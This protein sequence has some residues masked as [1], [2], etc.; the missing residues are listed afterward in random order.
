[1][2]VRF[3]YILNKTCFAFI[4]LV[5]TLI[6][7][8]MRASAEIKSDKCDLRL[9]LSWMNILFCMCGS[10]VLNLILR[11][12]QKPCNLKPYFLS[13]SNPGCP[14]SRILHPVQWGKHS[15]VETLLRP[16][17]W[18]PTGE[19]LLTT[20]TSALCQ[21]LQNMGFQSLLLIVFWL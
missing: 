9:S 15:L 4:K 7:S 8:W 11:T 19:E 12:L 20:R 16:S 17:S 2:S 6:C 18:H 21:M 1:M 14:C 3:Q 13:D 5:V 10:W